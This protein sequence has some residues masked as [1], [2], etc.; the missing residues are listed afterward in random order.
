MDHS[1]PC[2]RATARIH[3]IRSRPA[4]RPGDLLFP[5]E[6]L[7]LGCRGP[8]AAALVTLE[9][10]DAVAAGPAYLDE[11]WPAA[12]HSG[13]GEE[14]LAYPQSLRDLSRCEKRVGVG[15]RLVRTPSSSGIAVHEGVRQTPAGGRKTKLRHGQS[16]FV[17][18]PFRL[19]WIRWA[20]VPRVSDR[21]SC[22]RRVSKP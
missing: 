19:R 10:R 2:Q 22:G 15:H 12:G 7:V 14:A 16:Y 4:L 5:V 21:T 6:G 3:A 18:W 11:A 9:V 8:G 20:Q 13:F 17:L 1:S